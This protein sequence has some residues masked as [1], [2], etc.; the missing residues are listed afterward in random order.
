M[1]NPSKQ[2][3]TK[4]ETAICNA[5]N[6]WAG[7]KVCERVALKGS[8]D[9]GDMRLVVDELTLTCESK[10]S[11]HYPTVGQLDEFKRQTIIENANAGQDGG[12]L[13]VNLPN[14]SMNRMEVWMQKSTYLRINGI[15]RLLRRPDLSDADRK[16]AEQALVDG[17]FD[18]VRLTLVDFLHVT[19]GNPSWG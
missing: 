11:K 19:F 5:I 12:L 7:S 8:Y 14:K 3:G 13:F 18:W 17:A 16:R 2:A 9:C 1:A 6:D 10:H 4:Q 15:D